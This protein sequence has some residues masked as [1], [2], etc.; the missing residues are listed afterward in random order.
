MAVAYKTLFRVVQIYKGRI[1]KD[2]VLHEDRPI[3]A[4]EHAG[5]DLLVPVMGSATELVLFE[6]NG[7]GR[8]RVRVCDATG[9][10]VLEGRLHRPQGEVLEMPAILLAG[11]R[12]AVDPGD[13]G[14]FSVLGADDL[15]IFF[16]YVRLPVRKKPPA[17]LRPFLGVK[18]TAVVLLSH[19]DQYTILAA[20][21]LLA[22]LL[23]GQLHLP[24]SSSLESD[25][26]S[27]RFTSI[28]RTAPSRQIRSHQ[29]AIKTQKRQ[30]V[31]RE[32]RDVSRRSSREPPRTERVVVERQQATNRAMN[33]GALKALNRAMASSSAVARLFQRQGGL[34]TQVDQELAGL[35]APGSGAAGSDGVSD[36]LASRTRP[37]D[38]ALGETS[39]GEGPKLGTPVSTRGTIGGRADR[40]VRVASIN[41]GAGSVSGSG[42][43]KAAIGQ[44]VAA[45]SGAIKFCYENVLRANPN[46]GSGRVTVSFKIGPTGQVLAA[47][48]EGNTLAGGA[49]VGSCITRAIRRWRFPPSAGYAEVRYPFLF[50]TGLK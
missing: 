1:Q 43:G 16:Q 10:K 22:F 19:M 23:M 27:R 44:V 42:L 47:R 50:S 37:A 40:Q 14:L 30:S 38:G 26:I 20:V 36:P 32:V 34:L 18:D 3:T 11:G 25:R 8:F 46:V 39:T 49:E 7:P 9:A 5:C 13:W 41:L 24:H 6:P 31:I 48:V 21:T 4:G 15:E 2:L 12:V 35:T 33:K 29:R 28:V 17:V 45:R